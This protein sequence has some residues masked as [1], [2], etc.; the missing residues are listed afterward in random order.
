[1]THTGESPMGG[2]EFPELAEGWQVWHTEQQKV[3]LTYRPD[4]FDTTAYPAPCMPTLYVTKGQRGRRPGP[5][6]PPSDA[7]WYVTLYLE[8]EVSESWQY[9][10][11]E[12]ARDGALSRAE[13]FASGEYPYRELYQVP[14]PEYLA[15]LDELTGHD[16]V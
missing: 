4:V 9:D 3:V 13:A 12:T 15:K 2:M 6:T 8:P 1:M 16:T 10:S 14:R 5:H 7:P 11:R